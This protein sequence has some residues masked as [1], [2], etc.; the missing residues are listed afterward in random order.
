MLDRTIRNL[1][2]IKF[3]GYLNANK[4]EFQ[5][6]KENFAKKIYLDMLFIFFQ[7]NYLLKDLKLIILI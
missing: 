3:V 4:L 6:V 5:N 7:M 1:S 2:D